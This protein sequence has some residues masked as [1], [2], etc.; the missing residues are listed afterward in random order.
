VDHV[1]QN[2]GLFPIRWKVLAE[3]L[4][5]FEQL[6]YKSIEV[7]WIV[8]SDI[9]KMTFPIRDRIFSENNGGFETC[10]GDLVASAEQSFLDLQVNQNLKKGSYVALTPCFRVEPVLDFLHKPYFAKTELYITDDV[11]NERFEEMIDQA[12]VNFK[13]IAKNGHVFTIEKTN[14]GCDILADGLEIGS[15]NKMSYNGFDW[16]CGT[17]VAEPRF[18]SICL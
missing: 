5:H 16:L 17:A 18:S 3:T 6:G 12:L 1:L 13:K 11:T 15:Y 2:D 8:P 10:Y 7:P 9:M 4:E 14:V